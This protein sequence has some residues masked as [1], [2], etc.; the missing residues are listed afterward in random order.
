MEV[1]FL[2]DVKHSGVVYEAG[3]TH[4]L[5]K[6]DAEAVLALKHT[7]VFTKQ[8]E[9]D[10]ERTEEVRYA[11]LADGTTT[12]ATPAPARTVA[13]PATGGP[14]PKVDGQV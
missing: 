4:D 11:E 14:A 12:E 8:R 1:R 5:A 7:N 2:R 13:Q 6:E 10:F 3:T 9:G